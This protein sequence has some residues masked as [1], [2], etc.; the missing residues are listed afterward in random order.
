MGLCDLLNAP[1]GSTVSGRSINVAKPKEETIFSP[2]Y[3]ARKKEEEERRKEKEAQEKEEKRA[4][5]AAK[6]AAKQN[7]VAGLPVGQV[8]VN[9]GGVRKAKEGKEVDPSKIGPRR[10]AIEVKTYF[11]GVSIPRI[12]HFDKLSEARK[13]ASQAVSHLKFREETDVDSETGKVVVKKVPD[14][15]KEPDAQVVDLVWRESEPTFDD[16]GRFLN[17]F[18]GDFA[19]EASYSAE[20]FRRAYQDR[21]NKEERVYDASVHNLITVDND[22]KREMVPF[23][24]TK[25]REAEI[26]DLDGNAVKVELGEIDAGQRAQLEDKMKASVV[27]NLN[28]A[29]GTE[30]T[31]NTT[32]PAKAGWEQRARNDRSTF[33]R[34]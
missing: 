1:V 31:R 10:S 29:R 21:C 15:F 6:K 30:I 12:D 25:A 11:A 7:V 20:E 9:V 18:V 34:G 26:L 3:I 4:A 23:E 14:G 17:K 32:R 33:S 19:R 28:K 16:Q 22:P 27:R 8:L 24:G 5:N 13:Y 2:S